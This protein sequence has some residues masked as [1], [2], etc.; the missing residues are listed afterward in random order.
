MSLFTSNFRSE[1]PVLLL[2]A[3]SLLCGEAALRL[4]GERLSLDL[5]HLASLPSIANRVRLQPDSAIL[6][7]GNSLTRNGVQLETVSREFDAAGLHGARLFKVMPDDTSVEDWYYVFKQHFLDAGAAPR[8]VVVGFALDQLGDSIPVSPERI[9][10]YGGLHNA[11]ELFSS[12]LNDFGDR[13]DYVFA[14][15]FYNFSERERVRLRV[16]DAV[17]PGYRLSAPAF[18]AALRHKRTPAAPPQAAPRFLRLRRFLTACAAARVVPFFVAMPVPGS[19]PVDP[20]L[21]PLVSAHHGIFLDLRHVDGLQN[22]HFPDGYHLGNAGAALYSTALA[23]RLAGSIVQTNLLAS[24]SAL[25]AA[26]S[27]P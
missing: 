13:C 19:Y 17:V 1:R 15:L 14:S 25:S 27:A 12:D 9:A 18:N 2:V 26:S 21:P 10:S 5:R 6:F 11:A 22:A 24:G 16:L 4:A 8:I 23:S 20:L 3:A 7:L